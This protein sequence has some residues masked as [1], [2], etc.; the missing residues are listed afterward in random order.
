MLQIPPTLWSLE[1]LWYKLGFCTPQASSHLSL[2][3]E[4]Y[5]DPAKAIT[6][7][8]GKK[9]KNSVI[10]GVFWFLTFCSPFTYNQKPSAIEPTC[11]VALSIA[12]FSMILLKCKQSLA[13]LWSLTLQHPLN[14]LL[15]FIPNF[16]HF[17]PPPS[18]NY[19]L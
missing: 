19:L 11:K 5:P 13:L 14:D 8:R 16:F 7:L 18:Q 2:T 12:N 4:R 3:C 1:I 10:I 9:K 15:I 17:F 6:S